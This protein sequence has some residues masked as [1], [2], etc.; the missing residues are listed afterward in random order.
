MALFMSVLV[1]FRRTAAR[2]WHPALCQA[3]SASMALWHRVWAHPR[4]ARDH[5]L[6]RASSHADLELRMRQWSE[7]EQRPWLPPR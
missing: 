3:V 6:G 1:R 7:F 4:C 5:F 2:R